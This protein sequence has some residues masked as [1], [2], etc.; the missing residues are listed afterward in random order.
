MNF[1]IYKIKMRIDLKRHPLSST[2]VK[3]ILVNVYS[4][5][6]KKMIIITIKI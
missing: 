4:A 6:Y 3:E 2:C 1:Q 5:D